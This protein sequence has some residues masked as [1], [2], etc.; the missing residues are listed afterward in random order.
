MSFTRGVRGA[1][2]VTKDDPEM[3]L[4]STRELLSAMLEANPSMRE[5]DIASALFTV[6]EDI[7]SVFPARAARQMGWDN[8]ALMCA[9]EMSVP[10]SPPFCIWILLHW[11]TDLSQEEVNNVYLGE[12]ANLRPDLSERQ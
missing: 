11:N 1:T 3:V 5:E 2:T 7:R 4:A 8:A 12:A 6:T 10:G 9:C